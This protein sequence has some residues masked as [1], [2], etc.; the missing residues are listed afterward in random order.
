MRVVSGCSQTQRSPGHAWRWCGKHAVLAID[1]LTAVTKHGV[2]DGVLEGAAG[3][4]GTIALQAG[5]G[6]G[7]LDVSTKAQTMRLEVTAPPGVSLVDFDATLFPASALNGSTDYFFLD[8]KLFDEATG[9]VT[10]FYSY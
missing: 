6:S 8:L 2:L 5:F 3:V 1:N 4:S 9:D 10:D 7:R